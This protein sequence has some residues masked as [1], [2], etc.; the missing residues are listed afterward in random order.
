MAKSR[1][2]GEDAGAGRTARGV[3]VS[4]LE[5]F[6][7][8]AHPVM[9]FITEEIWQKLPHRG[10][11]IMMAEWPVARQEDLD[12]AAEA[13]MGYLREVIGGIRRIRSELKIPSSRKVPARL[14]VFEEDKRALAEANLHHIVSQA[15]LSG[16]EF[17]SA[18]DDPSAYARGLV[19]ATE[20]FVPL[21]EMAGFS[22]EISRI[23]REL[24]KLEQD[25]EKSRAKLANPSFLEKA[26]TA[27]VE[28]EQGK[29]A[30]LDLKMEKLR[31]QLG[32]LG[33]Q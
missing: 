23:R 9:P 4:V 13:E 31:E 21:E 6:M 28:K 22:D 7:R 12:G 14:L 30:D 10:D 19:E 15:R 24:A 18:V 32:I 5:Q 33:A 8:L 3:L 29:L 16:V 17:V 1:L 2:Y 20:I 11:S 27:V 25:A 26:P